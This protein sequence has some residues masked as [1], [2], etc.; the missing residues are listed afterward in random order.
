MP[1][2]RQP[3]TGQHWQRLPGAASKTNSA[4]ES[5]SGPP[6]GGPLGLLPGGTPG[7]GGKACLRPSLPS[8]PLGGG[9]HILLEL[10]EECLHL[11]AVGG[12]VVDGEGEG[13][14]ELLPFPAEL[15]RLHGGE[16]VGLFFI[17]MDGEVAEAHPRQAG[18]GIGVGR[19]GLPGLAQDAVMAAVAGLVLQVRRLE[20]P[21]L[22]V[23]GRPEEG[24]GLVAL[25]EGGVE[26]RQ[27]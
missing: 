25:V 8:Q 23:I 15:A 20:G 11:P 14:Q 13:Q 1:S 26:G 21:E 12:G 27:L 16:E 6:D 5:P 17:G 19:R 18:D 2:A 4:A 10:A 7:A 9:V 22:V 3:H 24:E